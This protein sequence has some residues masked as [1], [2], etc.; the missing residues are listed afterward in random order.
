[1][2]KLRNFHLGFLFLLF[3]CQQVQSSCICDERYKE[4]IK[5]EIKAELMAEVKAEIM[6]EVE[7]S[8]EIFTNNTLEGL[9]EAFDNLWN[10]EEP[11]L[12]T[13]PNITL[14]TCPGK[15]DSNYI[16]V[17]DQCFYFHNGLEMKFDDSQTFCA[18][19]FPQ[20]FGKIY[21]PKSTDHLD[22]VKIT[23]YNK[24]GYDCFWI[25]IDDAT[26]EGTITYTSDG[27]SLEPSI[28][29]KL[30][31]ENYCNQAG[32]PRGRKGSQDCDY[33]YTCAKTVIS[34]VTTNG[35]WKQVVCEM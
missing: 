12:P 23:Y 31:A 13:T 2:E 34:I 14:T 22:L 21:E 15:N 20:G 33:F 8:I 28:Q 10:Q 17:E 1:M 26:N 29:A 5:A 19:K 3:F 4:E 27:T 30:Q 25:G 7:D 6:A 16:M 18:S 35:S 11:T 24:H 9:R 32:I